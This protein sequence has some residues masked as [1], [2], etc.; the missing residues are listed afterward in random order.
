MK[1]KILFGIVLIVGTIAS[2][3]AYKLQECGKL[4]NLMLNDIESFADSS[5]GCIS[6]TNINNGDCT[7]DGSVYFCENSLWS[8]DCV[9]GEYPR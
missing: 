8:H 5:E 1:K 4:S 3:N 2:Y 9:R 6:K 7:T